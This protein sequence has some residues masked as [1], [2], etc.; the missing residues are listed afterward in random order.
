MPRRAPSSSPVWQER[1]RG[2]LALARL[3]NSP[4]VVSNVLAGTAL[5]A[6]VPE[7][8]A[9]QLPVGPVVLLAVAMVCFYTAGM[10]LNDVCDYAIDLRERPDRPLTSG[11]ISRTE[12][13]VVVVLLFVVGLVLLG[14]V[15]GGALWAG[16]VLVALIVAYD[17]WHK[18]N[19]AS[20]LLM[21]LT[22][23]M[24]YVT[25][26]V[27]FTYTVRAPLVAASV[28]LLAYLIGLTFIAKSET[29]R[30]FTR[31]WPAV[32]LFLP[33]PYF[34]WTL[35]LGLETLLV[36]FF[37]AWVG[38]SIRYVYE[39]EIGKGIVRLIAGIALLDALVL[40]SQGALNGVIVAALAFALTRLL[41]QYIKGT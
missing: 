40:L 3:S 29:E 7:G 1:L 36:V 24:V 6:T 38:F 19:P 27:S 21:A 41:Q 9:L 16:L 39:G 37:A 2:H 34:I 31:S 28:L 35:P 15:G 14:V 33:V 23:V 20:P 13:L 18:T 12:A 8:T 25:A 10:Y 32:L 4:T 17:L 30:S 11:L 5:A 22:R 26:Y